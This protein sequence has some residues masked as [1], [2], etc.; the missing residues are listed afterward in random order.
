MFCQLIFN[1]VLAG[2]DLKPENVRDLQQMADGIHSLSE[3]R[4]AFV[5]LFLDAQ[6]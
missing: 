3:R 5:A 1:G 6:T 4:G 2:Q